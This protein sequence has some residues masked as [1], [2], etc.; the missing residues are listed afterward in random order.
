[1]RHLELLLTA[2]WKVEVGP[3]TGYPMT[4]RH[5]VQ[6]PNPVAFLVRKLLIHDRR[7]PADRAKDLLYIHDT[8]EAFG[9]ALPELRKLW[10]GTVRPLL[11]SR[12]GVRLKPRQW[13]FLGMSTIPSGKL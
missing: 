11:S 13:S 6:I 5:V 10:Q 1:L 3:A 4:E 2:P 9:D 7:E 8:I 12:H